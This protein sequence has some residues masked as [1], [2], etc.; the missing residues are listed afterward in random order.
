MQLWAPTHN[1]IPLLHML[2]INRH[3]LSNLAD[4]TAL[5][6]P[7]AVEPE[8][9]VELIGI[10]PSNASSILTCRLLLVLPLI[11]CALCRNF[12]HLHSTRMSAKNRHAPTTIIMIIDVE[13][14]EEDSCVLGFEAAL[15][16][17]AGEVGATTPPLALVTALCPAAPSFT[18]PCCGNVF[19][20]IG[21]CAAA[22]GICGWLN[23][24]RVRKTDSTVEGATTTVGSSGTT[25][26]TCDTRGGRVAVG[27][28]GFTSQI[29]W[30]DQQWVCIVSE[31][32]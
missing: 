25:D 6:V 20:G 4:E 29:P 30:L 18:V 19:E 11:R 14:I 1:T 24:L 17:D 23:S 5:D 22:E 16:V 27:F 28:P 32:T 31:L 21:I 10:S 3:A 13:S 7:P 15:F 2:G 26:E 12:L 8:Y 9:V